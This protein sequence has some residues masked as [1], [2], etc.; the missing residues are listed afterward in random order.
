MEP[1][2][3]LRHSRSYQ[4]PQPTA[5]A[6]DSARG[7][8]VGLLG[9]F[10]RPISSGR[11]RPTASL[12]EDCLSPRAP[13]RPR[14]PHQPSRACPRPAVCAR[15]HTRYPVGNADAAA[16][17]EWSETR[18]PCGCGS[19]K[20]PH[21][22][23]PLYFSRAPAA[24]GGGCRTC[25]VHMASHGRALPGRNPRSRRAACGSRRDRVSTPRPLHT[26]GLEVMRAP[27]A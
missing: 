26:R 27:V 11:R 24:A 23:T 14:A 19:F 5:R 20:L 21:L 25:T 7:A 15:H 18:H 13:P 12:A 9:E 3:R 16:R 2:R 4:S 22:G 6:G 8:G 17:S 1:L 10:R